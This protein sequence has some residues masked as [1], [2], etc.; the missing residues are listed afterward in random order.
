MSDFTDPMG[1]EVTLPQEH[2]AEVKAGMAFALLHLDRAIQQSTDLDDRA[3]LLGCLRDSKRDLSMLESSLESELGEQMGDYHVT[4]EGLGTLERHRHKTMTAW[5]TDDLL[6]A[7]LD[8]RMI[9]GKTGEV[10]DETPLDK[11]LAV[12]NLPAPRTTVLRSRGLQPDEFC[13]VTDKG[14]WKVSIR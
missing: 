5:N 9:D 7:V 8:T 12:W 6:R 1:T 3:D 13:T 11:V 4:V 2:V 14:G 10:L